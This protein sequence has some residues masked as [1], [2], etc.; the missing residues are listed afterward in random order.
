MKAGFGSSLPNSGGGCGFGIRTESPSRL[1][2]DKVESDVRNVYNRIKKVFIENLDFDDLIKR[3]DK[4]H[5]LFYCD[6]PYIESREY[7]I[8]FTNNDH[9]RLSDILHNMNGK[10]IMSINPH[11]L[12]FKLYGDMN[13]LEVDHNYS[14]RKN[15]HN[16]ECSELIITN[17]DISIKS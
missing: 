12:A 2:L 6:P 5:T 3:Y 14:M 15:S 13:I 10:F 16:T 11:E 7:N 9:I 8:P 1:N 4:T 17:Y